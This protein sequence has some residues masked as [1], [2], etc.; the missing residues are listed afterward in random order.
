MDLQCQDL[1]RMYNWQVARGGML[2][3]PPPA[4]TTRKANKAEL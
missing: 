3:Q 2:P 4:G 1:E